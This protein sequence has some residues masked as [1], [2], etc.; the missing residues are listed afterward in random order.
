MKSRFLFAVVLATIGLPAFA[1]QQGGLPALQSQVN[2][3]QSQIDGLQ[4][5]NAGLQQQLTGLGSQVSG[6]QGSIASLQ[7][8]INGLATGLQSSVANL[9][10]QINALG[11]PAPDDGTAAAL[12]GTW[13][14]T[15]TS[16]QFDRA[17]SATNH[18][19]FF[20]LA[21]IPGQFSVSTGFQVP[22]VSV[23]QQ[24][25]VLCQTGFLNVGVNPDYWLGR[26]TT[27]P[28]VAF[29][30]ARSG[31]NLSGN[32]T[33]NGQPFAELSG[34][35]LANNFF[36]LKVRVPATGNCAAATGFVVFQGVASLTPDRSRFS[37]TGTAIEGDCQ[38]TVFRAAMSR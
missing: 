30:L 32:V 3:L 20:S 27:S 25:G 15:V 36:L 35:V 7:S 29:A 23:C 38:H 21:T 6:L 26:S 5:Q 31:A 2:A 13:T 19:Q 14:G 4:S 1:Q 9:Q 11:A 12:V 24:S 34:I 28:Q 10:S 33:Q 16:L 22:L 18:A 37:F 8:Q 17:V